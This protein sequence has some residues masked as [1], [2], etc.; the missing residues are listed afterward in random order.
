MK[1]KTFTI[2]W[3]VLLGALIALSL[4]LIMCLVMILGSYQ[5]YDTIAKWGKEKNN[6]FGE[7]DSKYARTQEALEKSKNFSLYQR[8]FKRLKKKGFFSNRTVNID[9]QRAEIQNNLYAILKRQP[10]F[11]QKFQVLEKTRYSFPNIV[12]EEQFKVYETSINFLDLGLLHEGD[13]LKLIKK[14][15]NHNQKF[16]GLFNFK[17]CELKRNYGNDIDETNSSKPHINANCVLN[18]YTSRIEKK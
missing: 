7:I 10:L 9:E 6:E 18:W 2:E 14:I 3:S 4:S 12:I 8:R 1:P 5:Y 17:K 13:L 16:A 15:E 11:S